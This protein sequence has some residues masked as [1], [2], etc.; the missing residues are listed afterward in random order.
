[1]NERINVVLAGFRRP[2]TSCGP[3]PTSTHALVVHDAAM[4][5]SGVG[6]LGQR[7]AHQI[8]VY[9]TM[10]LSLSHST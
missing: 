9:T 6:G 5:V 2:I 7:A 3:G 8:C 4:V 10:P 1:M